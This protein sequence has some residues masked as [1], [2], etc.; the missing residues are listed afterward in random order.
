M[1]VLV[2]SDIHSNL[3]ALDAVIADAAERSGF[4][5]VWVLGDTVGYGPSP[6]ECVERLTAIGAIAVAGNHDLVCSGVTG[7]DSL[8]GPARVAAE[9][10]VRQLD[11]AARTCLRSLPPTRRMGDFTLV[12]GSPREPAWEYVLTTGDVKASL[13]HV[14]TRHCLLGHSHRQLLFE[15]RPGGQV[16]A[17]RFR[18]GISVPI[19]D[20]RFFINPGSVGQP[21]DGDP[22]AAY[23]MLDTDQQHVSFHRV[24]Y[25][26]TL[27]AG[28]M[29]QAGL[30]GAL[31][32]RI[33][34]GRVR[35]RS[36][37]LWRV[38]TGK[39]AMYRARSLWS[40]LNR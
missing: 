33:K 26:I 16:S 37:R 21:R 39:T 4:S 2:I 9:W 18:P 10:T 38:L 28:L 12:H 35:T 13:P 22:R 24:E 19:K 25:D 29:K 34:T 3:V 7:M 8:S 32:T 30:P 27:V 36:E 23:A 11:G 31:I 40:R 20:G 14:Y 17:R 1:R 6:V 15:I 5:Q